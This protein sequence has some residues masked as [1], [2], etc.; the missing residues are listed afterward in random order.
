MSKNCFFTIITFWEL[1]FTPSH[2]M[3]LVTLLQLLGYTSARFVRQLFHFNWN[4]QRCWKGEGRVKPQTQPGVG[5]CAKRRCVEPDFFLTLS[6]LIH[7]SNLK[8]LWT[9][10]LKWESICWF[11]FCLFIVTNLIKDKNC[12]KINGVSHNIHNCI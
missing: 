2:G 6:S 1:Y 7:L 11:L 4:E 10:R 8:K 9:K 12:I 5:F 3:R